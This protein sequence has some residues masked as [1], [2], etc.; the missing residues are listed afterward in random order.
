[1]RVLERVPEY[2]ITVETPHGHSTPEQMLA[3]R[4]QMVRD[5]PRPETW[6][7]FLT[8]ACTCSPWRALSPQVRA[9]RLGH[10]SSAV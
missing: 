8:H 6:P 2:V 7:L 9:P 10:S 5:G 4:A 1:M 3:T